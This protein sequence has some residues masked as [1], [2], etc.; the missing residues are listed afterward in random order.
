MPLAPLGFGH[1]FRISSMVAPAP[2]SSGAFQP[3]DCKS[4]KEETSQLATRLGS[5]Y[6]MVEGRHTVLH[7]W[8]LS[9]PSPSKVFMQNTGLASKEIKEHLF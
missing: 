1:D 4:K 3:A 2:F 5:Q 6:L 8:E 9:H 7:G